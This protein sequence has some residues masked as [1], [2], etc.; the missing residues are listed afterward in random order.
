[1]LELLNGALGLLLG[2]PGGSGS[3]SGIWWVALGSLEHPLG[4]LG[5]SLGRFGRCLGPFRNSLG[6]LKGRL[7]TP[8]GSLWRV[9]GSLVAPWAVHGLF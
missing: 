2:G 4:A 8:W 9:G 3:A 1:M 5:V 7:G 6:V